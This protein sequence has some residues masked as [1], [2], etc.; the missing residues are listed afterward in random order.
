[1]WGASCKY[2]SETTWQFT[3]HEWFGYVFYVTQ[4]A[5][6]VD[7]ILSILLK[8]IFLEF[9][10]LG[11]LYATTWSELKFGSYSNLLNKISS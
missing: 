2:S 3:R 1:M 10:S 5:K 7:L 4:F 6:S 9:L 8:Y 11:V